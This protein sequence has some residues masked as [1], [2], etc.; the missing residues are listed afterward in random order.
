MISVNFGTKIYIGD[1]SL[2]RLSHFDHEKILIITDNFISTSDLMVKV[3][4]HINDSNDI[5]LFNDVIPDPTIENIIA[6][7]QVA[8]EF[9][10]TQLIALGG[11]SPIDAAKGIL[12][13]GKETGGISD[14]PLIVI[15]TTSGTGSEVTNFSIITDAEKGIKYP[16]I[17]D[18][19]L[20]SEAILDSSLLKGLP[21]TLTADTGIDVLTHAIE[22][23][24]SV[25]AND[26]SDALAEKAIAYV[27][28]YLSRAFVDGADMEAREKMH[29]ASCMAGLAFNQA[30][31]GLNHGIAHAA[32]AKFHIA[33]GRL[34][35]ILLPEVIKYNSGLTMKLNKDVAERYRQIAE[36]LGLTA[37]SA[38]IGTRSLVN[39]IT[40][41]L[42]SLDIP[43]S[44]KA[45]GLEKD[46]FEANKEAIAND[47]LKDKSTDTNPIVP[48]VNDVLGILERS[49]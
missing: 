28:K 32:G 47:S 16:L 23:Y 8:K 38:T 24:V 18:E 5:E 1:D 48:T 6:G 40:K 25:K 26:I 43:L 39:E 14:I 36:L 19:I 20:P 49:Y 33:H 21:N 30:S 31:L 27:F 41:L 37:T 10:P 3:K 11:G 34:N 17:S 4:S 45:F 42:K 2:D 7:I 46:V 22:A 12:Y 15:P 29:I 35:G 13:F 44:F 9:S